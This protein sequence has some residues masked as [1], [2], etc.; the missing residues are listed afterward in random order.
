MWRKIEMNEITDINWRRVSEA[1]FIEIK[2]IMTNLLENT[3]N[4]N[5][6]NKDIKLESIKYLINS[7]LS[8]K[9]FSD[10]GLT[11]ANMSIVDSLLQIHR[12][13]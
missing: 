13:L 1:L 8:K 10:A 9:I 11:D 4:I 5:E 2:G 7:L 12:N 3:T 6:E